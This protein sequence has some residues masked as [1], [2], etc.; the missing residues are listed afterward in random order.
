ML[1]VVDN[2]GK[3]MN[4]ELLEVRVPSGLVFTVTSGSDILD[5]DVICHFENENECVL[6]FKTRLG[7]FSVST[8]Q[9]AVTKEGEG[10]Q[11][12]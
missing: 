6:F 12:A 10:V 3:S 8:F 11:A 5:N 2:P 9:L 7:G 4:D 1:L